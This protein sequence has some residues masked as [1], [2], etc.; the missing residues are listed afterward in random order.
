MGDDVYLDR[1]YGLPL[2]AT[3]AAAGTYHVD[4]TVDGTTAQGV[5]HVR[6]DPM[7]QD[8]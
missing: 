8:E 1:T 7:L 4:V 5:V 3:E 2:T 6:N